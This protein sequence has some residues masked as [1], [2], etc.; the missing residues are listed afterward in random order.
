M[1]SK[2]NRISFVWLLLA[3]ILGSALTL[4]IYPRIAGE[5]SREVTIRQVDS[6]PGIKTF[7]TDP[8]TDE[9]IALDFTETAE[10]VMPAVVHITSTF[11]GGVPRQ[12]RELPEM[13]RDLPEFFRRFFDAPSEGDGAPRSRPQQGAGSGVIISKDGYIVTNNHVVG[14]ADKIEV[15]LYDN[16]VYEATL[17]GTDPNTDIALIQIKE[18]DLPSLA[19]YNSDNV[20]VGEWVLAVGNPFN[21]TSTVTAGIVSAKGRAINILEGDYRIESFIQTDAAINRGNSGGA[22][23]NAQGQLIGINTAIASPNGYYAGYGFAVPANLVSKVVQDLMEFGAVQRGILGVS[24][25]NIDGNEA[26]ELGFDI[27]KGVMV[28]SIFANS[29][30]EEAGLKKGDIITRVDE[31]EVNSVPELQELIA[32]KRPGD[33]VDLTVLRDGDSKTLEATLKSRTQTV[34]EIAESGRSDA[35]ILDILGV[36]LQTVDQSVA[37]ELGIKGGVKI[38]NLY[39]GKLATQTKIREGFIITHVDDKPVSKVEDVVNMLEGKRGGVM[40]EGVYENAPGV[41]YYAFGL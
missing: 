41:H 14:G 36:E 30:A 16:R 24:I 28:D 6:A 31:K 21:L 11:E 37:D 2:Q 7:Y 22:L 18:K 33:Q 39:S 27:S 1:K 20:K 29:A 34:G 13:Y 10:K 5:N 4:F 12:E 19:F 40:L 17:V 15:T 9:L 8:K 26:K 32:R 25:R 35:G 38:T 23:V 3:A